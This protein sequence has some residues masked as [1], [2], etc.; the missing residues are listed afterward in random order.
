[1]YLVKKPQ[2]VSEFWGTSGLQS[3]VVVVWFHV[4]YVFAVTLFFL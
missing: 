3:Y 4:A 1:V 2:V